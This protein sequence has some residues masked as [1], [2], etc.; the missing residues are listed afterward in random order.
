[1][2]FQKGHSI[3]NG[4]RPWN[5]GIVGVLIGTNKGRK[6]PYKSRP[7]AIGRVAWNKNKKMLQVPWNK[8]KKTGIEPWNK[9]KEKVYSETAI[10]KMSLAHKGLN[11]GEKHWNWN[12]NRE[13][14][15]EDRRSCAYR[16]W[17]KNVKN[18]DDWKC[19]IADKN[20][21]GRLEA[22]HI[23]SWKDFPE[24]RFELN[25]GITLCHAH[26]PKK[27]TEEA[28]LSPYFQVLVANKN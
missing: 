10:E 20:C 15:R 19:R 9:G 21:D 3:N 16:D 11:L 2:R 22:H 18:R 7:N 26:H 27:K 14:D 24:L 5:K 1:M 6:F 13:E 17:S 4:R 23:L 25:N 8:G 12:S 28:K